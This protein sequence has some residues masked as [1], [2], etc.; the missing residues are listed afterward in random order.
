MTICGHGPQGSKRPRSGS[1]DRITA[2]CR[3]SCACIQRGQ[4][5][6]RTA[7]RDH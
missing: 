6:V 1:G 4:P 3:A 7:A 5:W 2:W